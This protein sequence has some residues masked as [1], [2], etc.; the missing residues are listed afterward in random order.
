M[1]NNDR[2]H[3]G[4]WQSNHHTGRSLRWDCLVTCLCYQLITKSSDKT[5]ASPLS[6][7]TR[8]VSCQVRRTESQNITWWRHQIENFPRYWPFVRGIHKGQWRAALM[9]SLISAWIKSWVNDRDV[10]DLR[11]HRAHYDV[12]VMILI[13]RPYGSSNETSKPHALYLF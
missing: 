8:M 5:V 3:L 1:N 6:D 13:H 10:G 9:F 12:T 11:R 7:Q 2:W 4:S